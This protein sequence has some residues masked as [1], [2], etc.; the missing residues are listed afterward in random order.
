MHMPNMDGLACLD[1]IML[2]R[3]S[4][5]IMVSS[6]TAAGAEETFEAMSS[7]QWISSQSLRARFR[8]RLTT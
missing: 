2:E 6:L 1:R 4:R 3:P 8:L 5:V 7:G